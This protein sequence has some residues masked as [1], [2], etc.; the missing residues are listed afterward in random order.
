MASKKKPVVKPD[1]LIVHGFNL[2]DLHDSTLCTQLRDKQNGLRIAVHMAL[3]GHEDQRI[4]SLVAQ[5]FENQHV[6]I[7]RLIS[8]LEQV[9]DPSVAHAIVV[10]EKIDTL[11]RQVEDLRDEFNSHERNN[12]HTRNC[13]DY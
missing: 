4:R 10:K 8:L 13:N 9:E 2:R 7:M 3:L 11:M 6:L 1:P 5:M 12:D